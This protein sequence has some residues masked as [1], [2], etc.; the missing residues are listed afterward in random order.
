MVRRENCKTLGSASREAMTLLPLFLTIYCRVFNIS[1]ITQG[2]WGG[3]Y[4]R[5]A[6]C[7]ECK[8]KEKSVSLIRLEVVG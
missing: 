2:R 4:W 7:R 1:I 6:R 8:S 5:P 3:Q